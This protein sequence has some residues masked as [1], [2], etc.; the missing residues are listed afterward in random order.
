VKDT[1]AGAASA[2]EQS[3][4]RRNTAVNKSAISAVV[5]R[6]TNAAA[7]LIIFPVALNHLGAESFGVWVTITSFTALF[8]FADLGIGNGLLT[9][10]SAAF[11]R[12]DAAEAQQI[13]STGFSLGLALA[14]LAAL[15]GAAIIQFSDW[16]VRL[17]TVPNLPPDELKESLFWFLFGFASMIGLSLV[18]RAQLATQQGHVAAWWQVSGAIGSVAGVLWAVYLQGGLAAIVLGQTLPVVLA[19]VLNAVYYLKSRDRFPRRLSPNALNPRTMAD[20]LRIGGFYFV[21]QASMAVAFSSDVS[22]IASAFGPAAVTDYAIASKLFSVISILLGAYSQSLW[23]AYGEA[24]ARGDQPWIGARLKRTLIVLPAL[25]GVSALALLVAWEPI[26]SWWLRATPA[27]SIYL[28]AAFAAWTLVESIGQAYSALLNG[29]GVIRFQL[30][31]A[32]AFSASTLLAMWLAVPVYGPTAAIA[33]R[34]VC[35]AL[36]VVTSYIVFSK[37]LHAQ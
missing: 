10:L 15:L 35:Y 6:A 31:L 24:K 26:T 8:A 11:G 27:V 7:A 4:E 18:H 36:I 14:S 19:G 32:V 2:A 28:L 21:M 13:T 37:R 33:S 17:L 1:P 5:L 3:Q 30:V 12:A 22:L 25:A 29:L 9:R 34:T 20:L 16:P 23:P